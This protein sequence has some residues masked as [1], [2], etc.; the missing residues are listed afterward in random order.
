[1]T[2]TQLITTKQQEARE[3]QM[4]KGL[5]LPLQPWQIDIL[6]LSTA[7]SVLDAVKETPLP[8]RQRNDERTEYNKGFDDGWAQYRKELLSRLER[9]SSNEE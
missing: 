7:K 3:M 9:F 4:H 2:L 5:Y 6:I 8:F 1:M